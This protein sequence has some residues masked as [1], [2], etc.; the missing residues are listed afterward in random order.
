MHSTVPVYVFVCIEC[1]PV[2]T[3]KHKVSESQELEN[4]YSSIHIPVPYLLTYVRVRVSDNQ[5]DKRK[6][7]HSLYQGKITGFFYTCAVVSR[8]PR[9][10]E[11]SVFHLLSGRS[12]DL[13][14]S[15]LQIHYARRE[16]IRGEKENVL[17]SPQIANP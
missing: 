10:K 12:E 7:L 9:M 15:Q 8:F 17:K 4:T 6:R 5:A 2:C 16:P 11:V 3:C 14:E 1:I 13:Y